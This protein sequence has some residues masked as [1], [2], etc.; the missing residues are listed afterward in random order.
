MIVVGILH[1]LLQ[2][3]LLALLMLVT[4]RAVQLL[5]ARAARRRAVR[6]ADW[7]T[8]ELGEPTQEPSGIWMI[9][10]APDMVVFGTSREATMREAF[11]RMGAGVTA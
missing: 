10:V 5:R 8:F 9:R 6:L 4:R 11:A 3:G 7:S 2:L 1:A